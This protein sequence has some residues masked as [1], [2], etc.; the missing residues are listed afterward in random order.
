MSQRP[1]TMSQLQL[2]MTQGPL[3][4]KQWSFTQSVAIDYESMNCESFIMYYESI[5]VDNESMT[6]CTDYEPLKY[7]FKP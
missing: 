5:N 6:I 3:L 2:T 7:C 4:M 1:L